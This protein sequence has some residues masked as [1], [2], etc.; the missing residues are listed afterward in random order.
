MFVEVPIMVVHGST[1]KRRVISKSFRRLFDHHQRQ[2]FNGPPENT[3]DI[4]MA[5]TLVRAPLYAP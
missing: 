2:A 1:N 4:I 3:R 5:S